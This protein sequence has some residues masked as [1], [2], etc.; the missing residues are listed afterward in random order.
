MKSEHKKL[1]VEFIKSIYNVEFI[2]SEHED[3]GAVHITPSNSSST[4]TKYNIDTYMILQK[5]VS[6]FNSLGGDILPVGDFNSRMGTKYKDFIISDSNNF[7]PTDSSVIQ[8][9][10]HTFR[11]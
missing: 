2:K 11:N 4:K 6:L 8:T 9:D 7:L 1:N 10:T 5:E 3:L